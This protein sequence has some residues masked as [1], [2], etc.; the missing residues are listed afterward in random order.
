MRPAPADSIVVRHLWQHGPLDL[1]LLS[2]IAGSTSIGYAQDGRF[3][4]ARIFVEQMLWEAL[5]ARHHGNAAPRRSQ[6]TGS[7]SV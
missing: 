7:D 1:A 4:R 3:G 5:N 6:A 2:Q